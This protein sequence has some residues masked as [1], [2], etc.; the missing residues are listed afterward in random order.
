MRQAA[1]AC[2]LVSD[3]QNRGE[4]FILNTK[5]IAR[6]L[7]FRLQCSVPSL[8]KIYPTLQFSGGLCLHGVTSPLQDTD[9][10]WSYFPLNSLLYNQ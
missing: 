1:I 3:L 10:F 4:N 2:N 6:G 8:L 9:T 7:K 5:K